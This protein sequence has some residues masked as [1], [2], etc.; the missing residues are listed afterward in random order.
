[1]MFDC[2]SFI[3]S[4]AATLLAALICFL[5]A[6]AYRKFKTRNDMMTMAVDIGMEKGYVKVPGRKDKIPYFDKTSTPDISIYQHND[7]EHVF[8]YNYF[9]ELIEFIPVDFHTCLFDLAYDRGDFTEPTY[10]YSKFEGGKFSKPYTID[11]AE[12]MNSEKIVEKA[13]VTSLKAKP[14]EMTEDKIILG[15][16]ESGLYKVRVL[17][18][19]KHPNKNSASEIL[20]ILYFDCNHFDYKD[21][22]NNLEEV[23]SLFEED[24][25]E[26]VYG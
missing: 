9:L 26:K 20:E 18:N 17:A 5:C 23:I 1:M 4:L 24:S 14:F 8:S 12:Y 19:Y 10:L 25:T 13:N 16:Q 2:S 11:V 22:V 15:L 3:S 6:T 7:T 21:Y